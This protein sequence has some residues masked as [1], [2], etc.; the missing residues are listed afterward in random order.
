MEKL[1]EAGTHDGWGTSAPQSATHDG[2][3]AVMV[4]GFD[5]RNTQAL[6]ISSVEA[7]RSESMTAPTA[8]G[9]SSGRFQARSVAMAITTDA[10]PIA[11]YFNVTGLHFFIFA[12][13]L[14]N[15]GISMGASANRISP[16]PH[17]AL[18]QKHSERTLNCQTA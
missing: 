16:P 14:S 5:V 10:K 9:A 12:T 15:P 8:V 7:T 2:A 17:R 11:A 18:S 13:L 6:R 3:M 1:T 4:R